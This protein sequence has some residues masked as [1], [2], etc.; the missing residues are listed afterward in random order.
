[1]IIHH[2]SYL[3]FL[4]VSI[5]LVCTGTLHGTVGRIVDDYMNGLQALKSTCSLLLDAIKVSSGLVCV[6]D[7]FP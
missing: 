3:Y 7:M 4:R 5:Q 6:L 1:M 2:R